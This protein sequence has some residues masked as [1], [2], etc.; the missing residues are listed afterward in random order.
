MRGGEGGEGRGEGAY[1][2]RSLSLCDGVC[3]L[4]LDSVPTGAYSSV[5]VTTYAVSLGDSAL[6]ASSYGSIS[7]EPQT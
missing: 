7:D 1:V 3:V 6:S 5:S 2:F 4:V